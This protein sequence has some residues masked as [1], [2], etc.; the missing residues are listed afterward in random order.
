MR[1]KIFGFFRG[2][3]RSSYAEISVDVMTVRDSRIQLSN[4]AIR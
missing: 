1:I 2:L 4:V 3:L